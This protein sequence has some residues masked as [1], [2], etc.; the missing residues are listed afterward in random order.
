MV[1]LIAEMSWLTG[2]RSNQV[3]YDGFVYCCTVPNSILFVRRNRVA[4]FSGNSAP[5]LGVVQRKLLG[6]PTDLVGRG[7]IL[8]NPDLD[9]DS[10]G[11]PE[12]HAWN[13][14]KPFVMGHLVKKGMPRLAAAQAVEQRSPVARQ[15]LV[16]E[17]DARPVIIDRAPALHRFSMMAARPRLV[18]GEALQISPLVVKG[19]GADFDG[20]TM[21]YSVPASPAAVREAYDK[22][23]PSQNLF[24]I[25]KLN[26]AQYV[27][28]QEYLGGLHTATSERSDKKTVVFDSEAAARAAYYR[29]EIG[30]DQHVD[31]RDH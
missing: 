29:G 14:Y 16:H 9:M 25:A 18:K 12:T 4:I 24:S 2:R 10:V 28:Q 19:F 7:T 30:A 15:A 1:L 5:K 11:V 22:M 21:N 13:V 20:D 27:P 17:M 23:L 3:N 31:I 26:A 8:P 6:T